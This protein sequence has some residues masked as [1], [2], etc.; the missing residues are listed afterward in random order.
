MKARQQQ[1]RDFLSQTSWKT[2]KISPLAGDAS[3]RR[4][5]RLKAD[6]G[7]TTVLMDADP[8][9]GETVEPFVKIARYLQS[10]GLSAPEIFEIDVQNGFLL[11]EDLGD[12][13]FARISETTPALEVELYENAVD[14]L[15]ELHKHQ[16]PADLNFYDADIMADMGCLALTWYAVGA[17][18][19]IDQENQDHF[20]N[21]VREL[22]VGLEPYPKV[23]I[24]RDFHAENLIWLPDRQGTARVGLLDFQDAM[25]GHPA[26]D[27]MSLLKDARRDVKPQI[28]TMMID[29]YINAT[30]QDAECFKENCAIVS[31]QRNLRIL[32]VFARLSLHSGKP[33]YVDLIPRVW[34]NL[35]SDLSHPSVV[36]LREQV[37][38]LLPRPTADILEILKDKC[39]TVP[40]L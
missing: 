19:T 27:L 30:Q 5:D 16:P 7:Q 33:G 31:A 4:Y 10:I 35:V 9:K 12:D 21:A 17:G 32:G 34:Q 3:N 18:L 2:A 39:G 20:R 24:Q 40:H 37:D 14:V 8:E 36:M 15:I 11:I 13:L 28:I 25:L 6:N 38:R 26:Y 23:L 29:R 22:I 1:I